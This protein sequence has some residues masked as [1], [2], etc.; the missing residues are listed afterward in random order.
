MVEKLR[1]PWEFHYDYHVI[2]AFHMVQP[3]SR[4]YYVQGFEL[5]I[6]DSKHYQIHCDTENTLL[7]AHSTKLDERKPLLLP[8]LLTYPLSL[9]SS[10]NLPTV[11]MWLLS[12]STL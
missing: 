9:L 7:P 10:L 3:N 5:G 8:R 11:T 1:K 6:Y 12:S 4:A 2:L